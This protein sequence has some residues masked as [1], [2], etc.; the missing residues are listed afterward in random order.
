MLARRWLCLALVSL[1]FSVACRSAPPLRAVQPTAD[2][3]GVARVLLTEIDGDILKFS[4]LNLS[5]TTLV[6]LR[7]QITLMTPLGLRARESGGIDRTYNIAPGAAHDVNVRFDMSDL[8]AR[9]VI[10]VRFENALLVSGQP[11]AIEP[12]VLQVTGRERG[13]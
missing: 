6:V 12:I 9:D 5:S 7:D 2:A 3:P 11:V 13:D 10:Q 1:L 4:V 8:A